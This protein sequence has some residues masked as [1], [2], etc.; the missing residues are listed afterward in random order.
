MR[1]LHKAGEKIFVDYAGQTVGI[2]YRLTEETGPAQI[3]VSVLGASSYT[4]AEGTW[5][6]KLPDWIGSL[7]IPLRLEHFSM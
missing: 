6:Q 3:F 1:Q 7:T 4:Y 5:I 2:I